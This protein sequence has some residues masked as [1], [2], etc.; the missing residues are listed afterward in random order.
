MTPHASLSPKPLLLGACTHLEGPSTGDLASAEGVLR[1]EWIINDDFSLSPLWLESAPLFPKIF[2]RSRSGGAPLL[3]FGQVATGSMTELSAL[4]AKSNSGIRVYGGSRFAL[5]S[6]SEK[7]P[8]PN[9]VYF[10]PK[11]EVT[12]EGALT[13]L[14]I[15]FT[16]DDFETSAV[17]TWLTGIDSSPKQRKPGILT[18]S[19]Q[20]HFS[21][22]SEAVHMA[23]GQISAGDLAK[24]VLA[25]QSTFELAEQISPYALLA[26]LMGETPACFHFCFEPTN[27]SGAFLGASPEQLYRRQGRSIESEAVAGTRPRSLDPA[28]DTR[29]ES[30]LR[31]F[32]KEQLEHRLV[33]DELAR[34]FRKICADFSHDEKPAVLKLSR[35]QHLR[36][37]LR[38][39]LADGLSDEAIL[40][41]LHPTPATCGS[42]TLEARSFIEK[43]ELFDRG[44]YAG[45]L[46]WI[47]RDDAEFC[48]A[49]R[50]MYRIENR[51]N[52]FAGAG[53]VEGSDAEREWMEL[54]DKISGVIHILAP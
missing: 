40:E 15:H 16:R 4:L 24:V 43:N 19:D 3:A 18:R 39:E 2:W 9:E 21:L 35:L 48:V 53:I 29:L 17:S 49:I 50:S 25:R 51:L 45:P 52:V 7:W 41:A 10:I 47:S 54:E 44:W 6:S 38:G 32:T 5:H 22:W 26:L 12:R 14:A 37:Q 28:E 31:E 13:K 23:L 34:A 11:V 20:P 8:F 1:R 36:T 30:Q 33:V 27:T 42:P 46:G